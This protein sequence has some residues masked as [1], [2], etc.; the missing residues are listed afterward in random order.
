MPGEHNSKDPCKYHNKAKAWKNGFNLLDE[1]VTSKLREI[2]HT[3]H[4]LFAI[5]EIVISQHLST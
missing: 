3:L 5:L 2:I 4:G 1:L